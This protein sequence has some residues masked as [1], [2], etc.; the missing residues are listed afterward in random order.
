MPLQCMATRERG[1]KSEK[2]EAAGEADC[3][4]HGQK[5][6]WP[7]N[8]L[9][10]LPP[11]SREASASFP[12]SRSATRFDLVAKLRSGTHVREAPAFPGAKQSLRL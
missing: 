2:Q 12:S 5:R 9:G 11:L 8:L 7:D 3:T 6:G 1:Q 4:P 10:N